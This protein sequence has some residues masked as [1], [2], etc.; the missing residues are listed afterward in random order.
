MNVRTVERET[1]LIE[2]E[3]WEARRLLRALTRIKVQRVV[4]KSEFSLP[5]KVVVRKL[6]EALGE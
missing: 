3:P 5:E 4:G 1:I 6:M 2:L